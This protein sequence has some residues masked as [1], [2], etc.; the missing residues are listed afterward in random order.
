MASRLRAI[1]QSR[2]AA[3]KEWAR[4]RQREGGFHHPCLGGQWTNSISISHLHGE[5]MHRVWGFLLA[6]PRKPRQQELHWSLPRF[7]HKSYKNSYTKQCVRIF[8]PLSGNPSHSQEFFSFFFSLLTLNK[9]LCLPPSGTQEPLTF[10]G[11]RF[12]NTHCGG[13]TRIHTHTPSIPIPVGSFVW[14]LG[15]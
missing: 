6:L 4:D 1:R 13:L 7:Y 9:V 12:S 5:G 3:N 15:P 10:G 8:F 11:H 14:M 2:S